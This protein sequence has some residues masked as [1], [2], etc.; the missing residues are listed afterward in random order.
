MKLEDHKIFLQSVSGGS[1][2]TKSQDIV[3]SVYKTTLDSHNIDISSIVTGQSLANL[4]IVTRQSLAKLSKK[5]FLSFSLLSCLQS[6][7]YI[8]NYIN[9][10]LDINA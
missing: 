6:D 8:D 1:H 7:F 10:Q 2:I 3:I 5:L 4:S 9:T